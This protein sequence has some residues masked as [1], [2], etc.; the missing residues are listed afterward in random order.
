MFKTFIA[1]LFHIGRDSKSARVVK[2]VKHNRVR[3][4]NVNA[5]KLSKPLTTQEIATKYKEGR[6]AEMSEM[7]AGI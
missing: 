3:V 7:H 5:L 6:V 4:V 2:R 1:E